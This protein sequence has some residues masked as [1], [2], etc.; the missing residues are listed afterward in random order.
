M[1]KIL[2]L[3]IIL[4]AGITAYSQNQNKY[5]PSGV[6]QQ[7][8][9]LAPDSALLIP[10]GCGVPWF[11]KP[12]DSAMKR[13]ALFF[14]TCNHK[15]WKYDPSTL[16]WDSTAGSFSGGTVD[17]LNRF[18]RLLE[19]NSSGDSL[20]FYISGTRNAVLDRSGTGTDNPNVGSG[21]R[22][23]KP[24]TQEIKTLFN[25]WG[26]IWDSTSNS[27]G[28][29][30]KPDSFAI[31]TKPALDK[32]KDSSNVAIDARVQGDVLAEVVDFASF[33]KNQAKTI[34]VKDT[35]RGGTFHLYS[36]SDAVDNGMIFS[37]AIGRKWLR[38]VRTNEIKGTWYGM[39]TYIRFASDAVN[40]CT[41]EF[42]A[43]ANYI[44]NHKQFTTLYIPHDPF[45][46]DILGD[47]RLGY[48]YFTS[49][50]HLDKDITI[51]GDGFFNKP[52]TTLMWKDDHDTCIVL[53]STNVANITI[54]NFNLTQAKSFTAY[55][56][57][58]HIIYNSTFMHLKNINIPY[59]SGDGVRVQACGDLSSPWYGN[60][61][62]STI[63]ML[64]TY[65]CMNGLWLEGCDANVI[66]VTNSSF[67][68][69]RRW[70]IYDNSLLG[71]HYTR[72]HYSANG[73]QGGVIVTY[74]GKYY[75]PVDATCGN[76]I[77]GKSPLLHP[78]LWYEVEPMGGAAAWDTA[79]IYWSGGVAAV[80]NVNAFSTFE[81]QYTESFQP[82]TI[83][84]AR[85]QYNGGDPGSTV[86]GGA[87]TRTLF[88]NYI[89]VTDEQS[90]VQVNKMGVG[91]AP[92]S[93]LDWS[94][95][96]VSKNRYA[97]RLTSP[98][99]IIDFQLGNSDNNSGGLAYLDG[100]MLFA[101][102]TAGYAAQ[103][104]VGGFKPYGYS[105]LYDLGTSGL[106]WRNVYA[107]NYYGD[108]S[109]LTGVA[110][111]TSGTSIL[112][113]NGS[114]GFSSAAAE[115]DFTS[116]SGTGTLTN[117]TIS[118][119]SNTLSNISQSSVTNLTS[120]LAAMKRRYG[121]AQAIGTDANITAAAGTTYDLPTATLSAN[122]TIDVSGLNT[123]GDYIEVLNNEAGFTWSFTGATV[124]LVDRTTT[125]TNLLTAAFYQI[126]R[127]NGKLIIIN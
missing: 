75:V 13:S 78:S 60:A 120:D 6:R 119:A 26:F 90:G 48:Y 33:S 112:K 117:K 104:D 34:F 2:F 94:I 31:T 65:D 47:G 40:D 110:P 109:T 66:E 103:L 108:G 57:G 4:F 68:F 85:S 126:R 10:T 45:G 83:L 100:T 97:A 74:D 89:I 95:D 29:T 105:E 30:G 8:R 43:A 20:V 37:D 61:D 64:Q 80:V 114:G 87:W 73:K 22:L 1:K 36:G 81:Y 86:K 53:K 124:Y 38:E 41:D 118:G 99:N 58:A 107:K 122:R 18:I 76:N 82:P 116:P 3:L 42:M 12:A 84:N 7:P 77:V 67:V 63:D 98:T 21:F 127:I 72:N 93:G 92:Y 79:T 16:T 32:H 69:N 49:T 106:K 121:A 55:D 28:L 14:D 113:G 15:L 9:A 123:D 62:L 5:I 91:T 17:T 44:Y 46:M 59:A 27:N 102:K 88:N 71:N 50:L 35:L 51:K 23:V 25:S 24:S 111:A 115:T 39:H 125:V 56:T 52:L 11:L 101:C 19:K 54:E 70:G 96:L